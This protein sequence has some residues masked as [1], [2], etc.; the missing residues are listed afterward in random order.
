MPVTSRRA[1]F[2]AL[3]LTLLPRLSLSQSLS[4]YENWII[5]QL[6]YITPQKT[7]FM[8]EYVRRDFDYS[9]SERN[10]LELGRFS[11]GWILPNQ[12]VL[13][14]GA[15]HL[16]FESQANEFRT[17]QFLIYQNHFERFNIFI[18]NR[19]GLEQRFF[20]DESSMIL[21]FR[22]RLMVNFLTQYPIGPSVYDEFFI[23]GQGGS[24]F[25]TGWNENRFG[26]GIRFQHQRHQFYLYKSQAYLNTLRRRI[27]FDWWQLQAQ[28]QF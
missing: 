3:A 22:N 18:L 20:E 7:M 28:F 2:I 1:F 14:I 19:T 27:D 9:S 21:R 13:L 11:Y 26:Y 23:V 8:G 17:H 25:P 12:F 15:A 4:T 6:Q 16:D 24:K 5:A 10:F